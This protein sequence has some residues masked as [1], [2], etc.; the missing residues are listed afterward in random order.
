MRMLR[1]AFCTNVLPTLPT[2]PIVVCSKGCVIQYTV[3]L[4]ILLTKH[5]TV[6]LVEP[7]G[8]VG[9]LPICGPA[10]AY[11][12]SASRAMFRADLEHWT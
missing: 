1:V 7:G 8:V 11:M 4:A 5:N 10:E 3:V 6:K 2:L 9:E 12:A